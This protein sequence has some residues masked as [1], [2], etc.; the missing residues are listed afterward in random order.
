MRAAKIA[1]NEDPNEVDRVETWIAGHKHKDG[2]P[3]NENVTEKIAKMET[4][5][6]DKTKSI[7]DDVIALVLGKEHRG[8]VRGL[9]LGVTPIRVHATVIGKTTTMQLQEKMKDLRQLVKELQNTFNNQTND[10]VA[11]EERVH[12]SPLEVST[13]EK[14]ASTQKG[15]KCKLL[16]WIGNGQI[17]EA[18]IDCTDPQTSIHHKL[19]GSDYL[20]VCV[21][22]LMV[23]DVPLIHDTSELQTLEDASGTFKALPSKYITY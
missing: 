3:V 23:S 22:K 4:I 15:T 1:K 2:R 20:R 11:A 19:L 13:S 18:E 16:H 17:A 12:Q 9:G 5:P 7:K 21:K 8:R 14:D 10:R 6:L